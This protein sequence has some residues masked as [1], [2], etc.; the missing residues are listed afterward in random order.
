[1]AGGYLPHPV[2][3]Y[4]REPELQELVLQIREPLD[5][6]AELFNRKLF[7]ISLKAAKALLDGR[8]LKKGWRKPDLRMIELV[9]RAHD[10]FPTGKE[11]SRD[12]TV[13]VHQPTLIQ[14]PGDGMALLEVIRK[15]RLRLEAEKKQA[16][17]DRHDCDRGREGLTG[18]VVSAGHDVGEDCARFCNVASSS[19]PR[20]VDAPGYGSLPP[21]GVAQMRECSSKRRW[22]AR[23]PAT[24]VFALNVQSLGAMKPR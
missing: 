3:R 9:W 20:V 14:E 19:P 10:R 21:F 6:R 22:L 8:P 2:R 15:E 5:E 1:M 4:L 23:Y 16:E 17:D 13:T 24:N 18:V 11:S 7:P 12:T